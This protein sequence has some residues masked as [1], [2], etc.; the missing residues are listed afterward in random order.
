[1]IPKILVIAGSDSGGG[2][3]I[4]GDIKTISALGGYAMTAITALTAQNSLGVHSIFDV[5]DYFVTA[6]LEA[7]WTDFGADA[8]KIGMLAQSEIIL[9]VSSFLEKI[10]STIPIVLDPIFKA[11][12]GESLLQKTA[13]RYL[14]EKLF[15][16]ITVLTPNI[17]E[18]EC[19]TSMA[20]FDQETMIKAGYFLLET[21]PQAVLMKGGHLDGDIVTDILL[22]S[23]PIEFF[24]A[25][26]I[27]TSHSHGTGCT[28]SSALAEGLGRGMG[29]SQAIAR[30]RDYLLQALREAPGFGAG[31]GPL[32]HG[33]K[34]VE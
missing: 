16:H 34:R 32:W 15:P 13:I 7:I 29:L 17:D 6:Q 30:A 18:A 1:M 5:E 33:I 10:P 3:G 20:I 4:Q 28:L 9:A 11:K 12:K 23:N 21:G 27:M 25:P 31:Q 26:R 14:K 2:A 22:S 24:S 8:I 19:L